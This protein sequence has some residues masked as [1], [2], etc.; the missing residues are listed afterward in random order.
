MDTNCAAA[1]ISGS[2]SPSALCVTY[3]Y[4][5]CVMQDKPWNLQTIQTYIKNGNS[6]NKGICFFTGIDQAGESI[7][8][9]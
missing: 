3:S 6:N 1:E 7:G 9:S 4:K 8:I 2:Y 5:K